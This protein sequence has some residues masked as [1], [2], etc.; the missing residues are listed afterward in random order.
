M[1][2]LKPLIEHHFWILF[3][4]VLILPLA[5]WWPASGE[6]SSQTEA[7]ITEIDQAF[8]QVPAAPQANQSWGDALNEIAVKAEEQDHEQR[9][10]LWERQWVMMTW[11][12]TIRKDLQPEFYR[13]EFS[14]IA[15]NIYK[16]SYE[17]ERDRIWKTADPF[18]AKT[19]KG[20]VLL[21]ESIIPREDFG[22]L[23]PTDEQMWDAQEDLWLLETLMRSIKEANQ[24]VSSVTESLV[25][26][27]PVINLVGG[28]GNY[29]DAE[30]SSEGGAM[31]LDSMSMDEMPS[32]MGS[33]DEMGQPG[34]SGS[35]QAVSAGNVGFNPSDEF[36][37]EQGRYVDFEEGTI[38]RK[39]G[40]YLEA[41]IDHERLPDF[42]VALTNN[43]WP[44]SIT[45][46]QMAKANSTSAT[47]TGGR[48]DGLFP[49]D[50]MSPSAGLSP[51]DDFGG[52]TSPFSG[53]ESYTTGGTGGLTDNTSLNGPYAELARAA[54]NGNNLA[55]VAISGIIFIYNPVEQSTEKMEGEP[56]DEV[57]ADSPQD[58]MPK[59]QNPPAKSDATE[60]KVEK[61]DSDET[62][63][64][65]EEKKPTKTDKK[66]QAEKSDSDSPE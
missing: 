39:R 57:P 6:F 24:G 18:D 49:G 32:M 17:L 14:P 43:A 50:D 12:N 8:S 37:E 56:G 35:R 9:I 38:C 34:G 22:S 48:G 28:P 44:V 58:P 54:T 33:F 26:S 41:I 61:T 47:S 7:K 1:D 46:V 63:P 30:P 42:L 52:G 36:G 65:S 27:V 64:A 13:E 25:R 66:S 5:G 23:T 53:G 20:T 29:P 60:A 2:K 10:A 55:H 4:F 31:G 59:K 21:Q 51:D 15:R 11:P 40:F 19:G 62:E 45:R 3:F 16:S